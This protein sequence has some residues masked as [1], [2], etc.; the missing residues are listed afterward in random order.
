MLLAALIIPG[1]LVA[2]FGVAVVKAISRTDSGRKALDR[3]STLLRGP[4][5]A[6]EPARQAA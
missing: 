6:A 1:G 5:D 4:P 3:V 2:L